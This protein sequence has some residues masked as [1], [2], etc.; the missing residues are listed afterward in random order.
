MTFAQ[1][2]KHNLS[3]KNER[4]T[5]DLFSRYGLHPRLQAIKVLASLTYQLKI[6]KGHPL[7]HPDMSPNLHLVNVRQGI[8]LNSGCYQ[9]RWHLEL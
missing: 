4:S 6:T 7:P 3:I 8:G 5:R 9:C 2:T 1:V